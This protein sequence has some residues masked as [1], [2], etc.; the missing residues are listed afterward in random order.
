MNPGASILLLF[1]AICGGIASSATAGE[2]PL[3]R[4]ARSGT[5]SSAE[6]WQ[7]GIVPAT[8]DRVQIRRGHTIVFETRV[9]EPIRSIHIAGTLT[10]DPDRDVLLT[11]GLIDIRAGDE[12]LESD[13]DDHGSTVGH[14]HQSLDDT[15]KPAL[16]VGTP[17]RPISADH[18]AVI[19]LA[20]V[21]GLDPETCPAIVCRGGRMEFHG[22]KVAPTWVKLQKSVEP[23]DRSVVLV[24]PVEGWKVGDRVILTATQHQYA[25]QEVQTPRVAD[26]PQTEER[27]IE[28]IA[29]PRLTL[30][31]P[32]AYSHVVKG[33]YGG[34][35]ALL[36]RNLVVESAN[37]KGPRG[38]TMYHRGSSGSISYAE[39]RHLG[40]PGKLGK[41]CLHFHKVGDSMRGSSVVGA[42]IWD[43]GNRWVTIHASNRLVIRDCVGYQSRGHGFFLEDG[44]EVDNILDGNLAVQAT[45]AVPLP[46]Q[47]LAYDRNDGAGFWWANSRNAFVRNV[48]V[49]CDAYGF[50]LDAPTRSDFDPVLAIRGQDGETTPQD[51][52]TL[53]FLRFDANEAHAQ[54]RYGV[55]LGGGSATELG[56]PAEPVTVGPDSRH[57]FLIRGLRIWDSHWAFTPAT[58]GLLAD[59]LELAHSDY[60]FWR[61]QFVRQAYRNTKTY[62]CRK[63]YAEING[64]IPEASAY[65]SPL[66]PI[67]DRP[68]VSVVM[69]L[70]SLDQGRL[71]VSG[72]SMDDGRIKSVKVNGLEA[73]PLVAD[74]SRW[75]IVIGSEDERPRTIE[76]VAVDIDGNRERTPHFLKIAG[77]TPGKSESSRHSRPSH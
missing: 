29:G 15:E 74:F 63:G 1:G 33:A 19:R 64:S 23:G 43:S 50:R 5:W 12:P 77:Q 49:E 75:E 35:V 13:L 55:N 27:T 71:R 8:G 60:G 11:V 66:E 20:E 14:A 10:F 73:R 18:S 40:K 34:E 4:S 39:F 36:T 70:E 37:P 21:A 28:A 6:S 62:Q 46:G 2:P 51:I 3:I 38:H 47:A 24:Q 69:D 54:R 42:S 25:K 31:R 53:P 16:L 61:P 67:D 22:A 9:V 41:Y 45:E 17:R 32:L 68:P 48:A 26:A 58:P 44:T 52:R 7:G 72:C 65:P 57:P 56:H 76:A 30:D 59:D